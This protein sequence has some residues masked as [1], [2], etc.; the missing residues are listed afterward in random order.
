MLSKTFLPLSVLIQEEIN[1][2]LCVL[3]DTPKTMC[4]Q[5]CLLPHFI[6]RNGL[7]LR[8]GVAVSIRYHQPDTIQ[9][10]F[11][12]SAYQVINVL[13]EEY[14]RKNTALILALSVI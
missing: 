7:M 2:L 13:S 5:G 8:V 9:G 11:P 12:I 3:K 6:Y 1:V 4:F 10:A 14:K